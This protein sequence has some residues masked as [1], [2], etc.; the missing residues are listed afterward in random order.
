MF[1]P[2][3]DTQTVL[4]VDSWENRETIDIRHHTPMMSKIVELREKYDLH[5]TVEW[6]ILDEL[7]KKDREYIKDRDD[8]KVKILCV[9]RF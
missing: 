6:Y 4:S 5:M 1:F 7:T 8:K 2:M 9:K 3:Q